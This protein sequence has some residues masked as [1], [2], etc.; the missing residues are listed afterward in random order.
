MN[1]GQAAELELFQ[2]FLLELNGKTFH[3]EEC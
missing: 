2:A 1:G 3:S